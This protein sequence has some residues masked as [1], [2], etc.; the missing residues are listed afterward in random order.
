M[1][2]ATATLETSARTGE[3]IFAW[4]IFPSL[5]FGSCGLAIAILDRGGSPYL[6]FGLSGFIAYVVVMVSER[7]YPHVPDW[8]RSRGDIP[9]D[10]AWAA[11]IIA[12]GD[13]VGRFSGFLGIAIGG[14]LSQYAGSTIWPSHWHLAAQLA[15]A[16]VVV[17]L[18]QYWV[19]RLQHETDILWRFHATHHSAPRLYWLNAARF[20]V[21]DIGLN[22]IAMVVPLVALGADAQVI[23]LWILAS[24]IHGISQ[25]ANM[26]IRCGWLNWVF[27]M[28]ELHRWH[29]SRL[30]RESNTNYGQT[31]ILWDIIFGTR[32][33]PSDREPPADIGI[34]DLDAFPMTYWK[35]MFSPFHWARIKAESAS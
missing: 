4:T 20:H 23:A 14:W 13:F 26:K 33:L 11:S 16:L 29:H 22:N 19:H 6:A 24:S 5:F 31:L 17:A 3:T 2:T 32:F 12:T 35:Q 1:A 7:I 15:L 21:V 18:F 34:A 9:T 8:N 28:A 10:A 27:S 30:V 25:H